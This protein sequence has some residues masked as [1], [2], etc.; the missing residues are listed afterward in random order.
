MLTKRH[1]RDVLREALEVGKEPLKAIAIMKSDRTKN[2]TAL[3]DEVRGVCGITIVS[4]PEPAKAVSKY[5]EMTTCNIKF[6][7]IS[8]S[9]KE[10]IKKITIAAM[11]VDGIYSFRIK[12]V[13]KQDTN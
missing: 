7:P 5:V 11:K 4:L 6:I 3:L 8:P 12:N 1:I 10:D 13:A 9:I 2:L